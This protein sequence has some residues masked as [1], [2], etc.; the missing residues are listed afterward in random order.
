MADPFASSFAT[1]SNAFA[2]QEQLG[3]NRLNAQTSQQ[4]LALQQ[5]QNL[6]EEN[7][8]VLDTLTSEQ[9]LLFKAAKDS[10][11]QKAIG[12]GRDP[13]REDFAQ[14]LQEFM[15]AIFKI[16]E[17]KIA[18][19]QSGEGQI[20]PQ[21]ASVAENANLERLMRSFF[22][23]DALITARAEGKKKEAEINAPRTEEKI[24]RRS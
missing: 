9:T 13:T 7:K 6:Q 12:E 1:V 11:I 22:V 4:Q 19:I 20:F 15:P 3:I 2:N 18:Q 5:L 17:Q 21:G 24:R 8:K 10:A 14:T 23:D 16:Q